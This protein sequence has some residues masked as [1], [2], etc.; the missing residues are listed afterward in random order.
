MLNLGL[1]RC[2]HDRAQQLN[3]FGRQISTDGHMQQGCDTPL[4]IVI[5]LTPSFNISTTIAFVN[6]FR[7]PNYPDVTRLLPEG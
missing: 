6:P 2:L 7:A 5:L 4:D 1:G 3:S